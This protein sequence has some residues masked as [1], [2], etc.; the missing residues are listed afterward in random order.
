VSLKKFEVLTTHKVLAWKNKLV[1]VGYY[2]MLNVIHPLVR[3]LLYRASVG[4]L[5]ATSQLT[6]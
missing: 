4:Q 1:V 3:R 6:T 2:M 5:T